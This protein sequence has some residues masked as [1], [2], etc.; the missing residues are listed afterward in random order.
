MHGLGGQQ[1]VNS[2]I[3][4]RSEPT[5][6][7]FSSRHRTIMSSRSAS[8]VSWYSPVHFETSSLI[9]ARLCRMKVDAACDR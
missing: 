2:I 9:F 8:S 1:T 7:R 6:R 5:A 3:S 4:F